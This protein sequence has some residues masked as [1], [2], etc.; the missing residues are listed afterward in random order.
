M[1]K[2]LSRLLS[3]GSLTL[4]SVF[5]LGPSA[6]QKVS[7]EVSSDSDSSAPPDQAERRD[8]LKGWFYDPEEKTYTYIILKP[9]GFYEIRETHKGGEEISRRILPKEKND[10][11]RQMLDEA[12]DATY[13]GATEGHSWGSS[14]AT[15]KL[16][17][18]LGGG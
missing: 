10:R 4:F 2:M 8:E 12:D 18:A 17:E 5:A 15:M 11:M 9:D 3:I 7:A 14:P 1:A 13:G 16:K 6:L